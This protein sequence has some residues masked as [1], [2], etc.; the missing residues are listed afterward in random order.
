MPKSIFELL[1]KLRNEDA[2]EKG[3]ILDKKTI[4]EEKIYI[5]ALAH[6][7]GELLVYRKKH[8]L[9]QKELAEKLGVSQVMI[10]KIESGTTNLS[11]KTLAKI[12]ARLNSNLTVSLNL[13]YEELIEEK[14]YE[15][16]FEEL[17]NHEN[18]CSEELLPAA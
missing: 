2:K 3:I 1:D 11:I 12:A 14:E 8:N 13:V 16:R 18:Q 7:A 4:L 6:I 17:I 10:S 15:T 9:T 5:K